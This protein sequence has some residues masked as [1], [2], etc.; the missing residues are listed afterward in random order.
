MNLCQGT[1]CFGFLFYVTSYM[2]KWTN[3]S[4][5]EKDNKNDG[6]DCEKKKKKGKISI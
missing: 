1:L 4:G 5:G 2:N 6:N 3:D